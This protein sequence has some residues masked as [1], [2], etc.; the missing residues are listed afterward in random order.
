VNL[1]A[2][3]GTWELVVIVIIGILV[4]GPKRVLEFVQSI[5]RLA[6]KLRRM[7]RQFT[8][9]LEQD[10][11]TGEGEAGAAAS[12]ESMKET[13]K[14]SLSPIRAISADVQAAARETRQALQGFVSDELEPAGGQVQAEL[15]STAQQTQRALAEIDDEESTPEVG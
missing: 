11:Q 9:M 15:E 14:E 6:G 1:F 2:N 8:S 7:S 12:A 4:L 5:R 13:I 3:I 10:L